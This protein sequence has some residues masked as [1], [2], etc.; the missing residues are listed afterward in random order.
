MTIF[1]IATL[2]DNR[3]GT[4][5][6]FDAKSDFGS[7]SKIELQLL[8]EYLTPRGLDLLRDILA[9]QL[10]QFQETKPKNPSGET[11]A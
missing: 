9:K 7:P 2:K 10:T 5:L 1:T 8:A 4:S 6:G 3:G 11:K